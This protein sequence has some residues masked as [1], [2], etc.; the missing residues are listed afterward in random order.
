[1]KRIKIKEFWWTLELF[2]KNEKEYFEK[3]VWQTMDR[4]CDWLT[5]TDNERLLTDIIVLEDYW[6]TVPHEITHFVSHMFNAIWVEFDDELWAYYI[7]FYT[8]EYFKYL[9]KQEWTWKKQ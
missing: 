2:S 8:K 1:M 3:R 7:W 4:W 6:N 9:E 5:I